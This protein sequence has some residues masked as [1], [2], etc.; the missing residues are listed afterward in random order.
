MKE[1]NEFSR[2]AGSLL[3]GGAKTLEDGRVEI[4]DIANFITPIGL[5]SVAING[6]GKQGVEYA[7]ATPDQRNQDTAILTGEMKSFDDNITDLSGRAY[8]GLKSFWGLASISVLDQVAAKLS[9]PNVAI[10]ADQTFTR[11]SLLALL[12][13]E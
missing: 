2:F 4:F 13:S 8:A 12:A 5:G 7:A 1:N 11:E 3:E 9:S 10:A 6:F